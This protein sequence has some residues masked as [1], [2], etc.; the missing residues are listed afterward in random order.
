[1]SKEAIDSSHK[2]VQEK[3]VD[4]DS[5]REEAGTVEFEIL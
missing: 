5:C 1:V 3:T 4:T 2:V